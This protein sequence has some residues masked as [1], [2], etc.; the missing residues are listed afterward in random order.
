MPTKFAKQLQLGGNDTSIRHAETGP[1]TLR[2][3]KVRV[4]TNMQHGQSCKW[5]ASHF[6]FILRKIYKVANDVMLGRLHA[7]IHCTNQQ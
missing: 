6:I 3:G 4:H 7:N 1:H 5:G 2:Q